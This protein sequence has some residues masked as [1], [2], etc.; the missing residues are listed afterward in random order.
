MFRYGD[1]QFLNS[2]YVYSDTDD[3]TLH[4]YLVGN[5]YFRGLQKSNQTVMLESLGLYCKINAKFDVY[6]VS[7]LGFKGMVK[8]LSLSNP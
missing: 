1:L 2:I 6:H 5:A 7:D 4:Q 3:R 8:G